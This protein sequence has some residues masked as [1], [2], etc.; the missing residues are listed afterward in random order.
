MQS[1]AH[2]RLAAIPREGGNLPSICSNTDGT[3]YETHTVG[4]EPLFLQRIGELED[5]KTYLPSKAGY[6]SVNYGTAEAVPFQNGVPAEPNHSQSFA[7]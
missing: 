2:P 6:G 5:G 1:I 7:A 4:S 3:K